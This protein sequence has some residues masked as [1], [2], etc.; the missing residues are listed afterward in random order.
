MKLSGYIQDLKELLEEEGDLDLIYGCDDE[1]NRYDPVVHTPSIGMYN[2][3][4]GDFLSLKE[5]DELKRKD[6]L[7]YPE[8]DK[9]VVCIN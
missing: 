7:W 6:E 9:K 5:Y 1:G 2:Y 3:Q 8:D 4:Q